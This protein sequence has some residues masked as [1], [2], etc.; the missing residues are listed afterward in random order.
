ME[1]CLLCKENPADKKGSH[2]VPHF[3]LKR[4]ENVEGKS[5]RDYELGF[6]IQEF[7]TT[8]H[9]GRSVPVDKLDEVF[10]E[11]SDE[12]I[13]ANKHPMVVDNFFCT[14]CETR[15]SKIESEYAKTLNKFENEVY[16]SEIR[17]EIG[18]LFWASVI[19]RISINKGSGVELTKN[20]NETLR[21]IL[22][23]VL[24]NELSEI[25]IEGMKEAKDIK[26]ISYKLL[27]CPDF[28]TKHATHMVIH[29]KLKNPYSLVIDE[30]LLFF[31]FK[32]NYNDYMNKDFFGI[33][34]EVEEAPTN[35]LQNTEMIYPISKEKMLEFN[36]ALIDHMKNTRV[37]KLNLFWD[38]L[39]RSLGGTGSSMPEEI[40]KELFA[41]LTSEEKRLGRKYNLED[42]R[43][44]TY[45]VLK[46]YAP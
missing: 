34:K 17:S 1:N 5:G 8:S 21:R 16:S 11:L 24:K 23:R 41:E 22:H 13:E 19:W 15:F 18:F 37:D 6:V 28:S 31:A 4:I 44:T 43:D 20:Q 35:K 33:Q 3:L 38:K 7:D 10:G 29:P 2:I 39:H 36:K 42:L 27:R 25:D 30:Y 46:K 12:E 45:K 9:F 32:D 40:K 26:K 14:S